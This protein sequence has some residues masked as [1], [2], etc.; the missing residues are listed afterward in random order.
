MSK[1]TEKDVKNISFYLTNKKKDLS[2]LTTK[3]FELYN[4]G[5]DIYNTLVAE[6]GVDNIICFFVDSIKI[7]GRRQLIAWDILT[8]VSKTKI[9]SENDCDRRT[10]HRVFKKFAKN[11]IE[12]VENARK[13]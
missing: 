9:A 8:G 1:I 2:L 6:Y 4:D 12:R 13:I 5:K 3:R 11:F 7:C 10:V